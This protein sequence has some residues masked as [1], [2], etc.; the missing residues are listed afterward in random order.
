MR[1]SSNSG[2]AFEGADA[3]RMRF[4]RRLLKDLP[5]EWFAKAEGRAKNF[6]RLFVGASKQWCQ[7]GLDAGWSRLRVLGDQVPDDDGYPLSGCLILCSEVKERLP[8]FGRFRGISDRG[9]SILIVP[10]YA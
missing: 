10:R 4:G 3:L 1:G 2:G 7:R 5:C 9:T 8:E 6:G